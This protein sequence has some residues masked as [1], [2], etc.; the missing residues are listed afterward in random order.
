MHQTHWHSAGS[1]F[2]NTA[3]CHAYAYGI[4]CSFQLLLSMYV[5]HTLCAVH[6]T[7]LLRVVDPIIGWINGFKPTLCDADGNE[8][9]VQSDA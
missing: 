4:R 5:G 1:N 9:D 8:H 2:M 3:L 7:N 6:A